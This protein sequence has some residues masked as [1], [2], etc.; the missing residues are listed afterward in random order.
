MYSELA[1]SKNL[2]L[3]QHSVYVP[4]E[5][6][7][8]LHSFGEGIVTQL[9]DFYAELQQRLQF[10]L[11]SPRVLGAE[12]FELVA[13]YR[14]ISEEYEH[15]KHKIDPN[16]I[17][18]ETRPSTPHKTMKPPR[19]FTPRESKLPRHKRTNSVCVSR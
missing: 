8:S 4:K 18:A 9:K 11:E 6:G 19:F 12:Y 14:T 5:E 10:L 7:H 3:K 16:Y 1:R 15:L 13:S 2:I 17:S